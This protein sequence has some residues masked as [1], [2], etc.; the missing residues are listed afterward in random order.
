MPETAVAAST[1]LQ[2][3]IRTGFAGL[4]RFGLGPLPEAQMLA[5]LCSRG[6]AERLIHRGGEALRGWAY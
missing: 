4:G 6:N 5:L 2:G 1:G 3:W